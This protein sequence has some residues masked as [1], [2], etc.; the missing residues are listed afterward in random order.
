[1]LQF[2]KLCLIVDESQ[3]KII[4]RAVKQWE[5]NTCIRFQEVDTNEDVRENHIMVTREHSGYVTVLPSIYI[6]GRPFA[7]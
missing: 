5:E 4:R 2:K 3:R 6:S 7:C 1:M